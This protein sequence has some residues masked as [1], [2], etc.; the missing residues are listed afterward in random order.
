MMWMCVKILGAPLKMELPMFLYRFGG[1]LKPWFTVVTIRDLRMNLHGIHCDSVGMGRTQ[2]LVHIY[3]FTCILCYYVFVH[4]I[5]SNCSIIG[6]T[7][8]NF[9][10]RLSTQKRHWILSG[11]ITSDP[12]WVLEIPLLFVNLPWKMAFQTYWYIIM[13]VRNNDDDDDDDDRDDDN[14]DILLHCL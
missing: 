12:Q 4:Q 7:L 8:V 1:L 6:S 5:A 3:F 2:Y 11:P 13:I 10:F 9:V 14:N